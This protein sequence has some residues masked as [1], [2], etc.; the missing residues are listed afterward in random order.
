MLS[1]PP[2]KRSP[3]EDATAS[4]APTQYCPQSTAAVFPRPAAPVSSSTAPVAVP[5]AV[6]AVLAFFV[7]RYLRRRKRLTSSGDSD[8]NPGSSPAPAEGGGFMSPF[9]PPSLIFDMG[10]VNTVF[11]PVA[12]R[13]ISS[14]LAGSIIPEGEEEGMVRGGRV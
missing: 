14:S 9:A 5:V 10:E 8:K 4:A 7:I 11:G 1:I 3:I 6:V 12:M 13:A 2:E